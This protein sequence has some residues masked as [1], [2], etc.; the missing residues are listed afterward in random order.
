M[1]KALAIF[2][3]ASA[4]TL[5]GCAA[6]TEHSVGL[7]DG[8][9]TDCPEWPRCVSSD[10][11]IAD[12]SVAPLR[13]TGDVDAAW[14]AAQSAVSDMPRTTVVAERDNYI[15]AEVI[16]PWHFYTDDLELHLRPQEQIIAVRSSGRIGYYDFQVNRDRVEALRAR[17]AERG[18]VA[19]ASE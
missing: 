15:H 3:A 14:Q 8:K 1:Q 18:V 9:F 17:L 16:S 12:K 7:R 10:S 11:S 6:F 4:L 2:T 13:I 5:S 19:P